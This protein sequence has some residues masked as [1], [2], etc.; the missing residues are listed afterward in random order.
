MTEYSAEDASGGNSS[1]LYPT[2]YEGITPWDL[3][4]LVNHETYGYDPLF[5]EVVNRARESALLRAMQGKP[6]F[7]TPG[8][9]ETGTPYQGRYRPRLFYPELYG[10]Y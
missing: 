3:Q 9:P 2:V 7:W 8:E 6:P 5:V 10:D 4:T 1:Y